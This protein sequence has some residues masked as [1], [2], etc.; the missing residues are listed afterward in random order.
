MR[1][2]PSVTRTSRARAHSGAMD[3]L[4]D[5]AMVALGVA[6]FAVLLAAIELLDRA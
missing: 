3:F 1:G 2:A 5:L 6:A 4:Y